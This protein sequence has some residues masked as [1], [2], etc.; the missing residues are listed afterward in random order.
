M[1]II[2]RQILNENFKLKILEKDK[3][4]TFDCNRDYIIERVD[5]AKTFLIKHKKVR[6]GQK[7]MYVHNAW[8]N[9][10]IWFLAAAELGLSFIISDYP[11]LS[12]SF[13]VKKK[14]S[15]YGQID[16]LIGNE[17]DNREIWNYFVEDEDKKI[18]INEFKE[19]ADIEHKNEYW[20]EEE[21]I[22]IYS[23]SSGS[24]GTPKVI[25][26]NHRFFYDLL[27]RNAKLYQL[28]DDDKCLHTK[29]MH[30]GSVTGVFFLPTL[31]YCENHYV[32]DLSDNEFLKSDAWGNWIFKEKMSRIFLMND[33]LD[34]FAQTANLHE[35][36]DHQIKI[37]VLSYVNEKHIESLIKKHDFKIFS[38]FGCVETSG[39]LFLPCIEN[40][41]LDSYEKSSMGEILDDFYTLSINEDSLLEV[42]MP[43]EHVVCTGDKFKIVNDKWYHEGREDLYRIN[44][45]P[46]YLDVLIECV[47]RFTG[48]KD[49]DFFDLVIDSECKQIYI[50]SNEPIDLIELNKF[51]VQEINV[52]SSDINSYKVNKQLVGKRENFVTGI[53]FDQEEIRLRCREI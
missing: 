50:R 48:K 49:C 32:T 43:D 8:P 25:K 22:L 30:H 42:V 20:A 51:I 16:F 10:L 7:I 26:H 53:K 36:T 5:M 1:K 12:N 29:G 9:F 17:N 45:T 19:W 14:L 3:T 18:D 13:S 27:E 24:T 47:E 37:Y 2:T 23:T 34:Q 41:D 38:I 40:K 33:M 4:E 35:K 44:G 28:T 52:N 39:P 15:L 21:S 31:K 46:I 6:P 11:K